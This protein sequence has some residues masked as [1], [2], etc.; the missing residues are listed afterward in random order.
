MIA[1]ANN[2]VT[3]KPQTQI[4]SVPVYKNGVKP[5]LEDGMNMPPA[6][7]KAAVSMSLTAI[8]TKKPSPESLEGEGTEVASESE[9]KCTT[10]LQI[11]DHQCTPLNIRWSG[12]SYEIVADTSQ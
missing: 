12:E 7:C 2:P 1:I 9:K 10:V 4:L 8:P 6:L 5:K 11:S 3:G